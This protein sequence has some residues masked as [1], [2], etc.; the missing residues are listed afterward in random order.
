[1]DD[2][3][4]VLSYYVKSVIYHM[5]LSDNFAYIFILLN[6]GFRFGWYFKWSKS[7]KNEHTVHKIKHGYTKKEAKHSYDD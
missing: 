5:V 3:K 7:N 2:N 4:K 6:I 1:M